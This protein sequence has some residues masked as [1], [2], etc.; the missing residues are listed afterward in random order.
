MTTFP[1]ENRIY[2]FT[3]DE[4]DISCLHIILHERLNLYKAEGI[5]LDNAAEYSHIS[6]VKRIYRMT[7]DVMHGRRNPA[8]SS[9]RKK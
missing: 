2:D 1:D 7:D 8:A 9:A 4:R 5:D 3:L 6:R